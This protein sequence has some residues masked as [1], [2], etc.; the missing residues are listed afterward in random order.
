MKAPGR[1]EGAA[2]IEAMQELN[3]VIGESEPAPAERLNAT[4]VML[5]GAQH[6]LAFHEFYASCREDLP[7]RLR[8]HSTSQNA[9]VI[10]LQLRSACPSSQLGHDSRL[11]ECGTP[12]GV[13]DGGGVADWCSGTPQHNGAFRLAGLDMGIGVESKPASGL[14]DGG[15]SANRG[16]PEHVHRKDA[17]EECD[18]VTYACQQRKVQVKEMCFGDRESF[19]ERSVCFGSLRGTVRAYVA[20][21]DEFRVVYENGEEE[22]L[23]YQ[24]M[25]ALML[26]HEE[27]STRATK[28]AKCGDNNEDSKADAGRA[29]AAVVLSEDLEAATEDLQPA[30]AWLLSGNFGEGDDFNDNENDGRE[31]ESKSG[32]AMPSDICHS[33]T[34]AQAEPIT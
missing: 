34:V 18:Q 29:S 19:L 26:E 13:E 9:D 30:D 23:T 17:M 25:K 2:A 20:A 15:K 22:V 14:R 16:V 24:V 33:F 28:R 32:M 31:T 10:R 1:H 27:G 11:S 3:D 4:P 12:V 8:P 6:A 21:K 7:R 5:M